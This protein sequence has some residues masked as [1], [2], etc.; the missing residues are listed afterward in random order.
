ML[1]EPRCP[2][3]GK[4]YTP[5]DGPTRCATCGTE[6]PP[7]PPKPLGIEGWFQGSESPPW[8]PSSE[9]PPPVPEAI[10]PAPAVVEQPPPLPPP[11]EEV[12]LLDEPP[13]PPPAPPP[14]VPVVRPSAVR[15]SSAGEPPTARVTTS[16][17]LED[18]PEARR[19]P[20]RGPDELVRPPLPPVRETAPP[21]VPKPRVFLALVVLLAVF[22]AGAC[23]LTVILY[24]LWAGF[25]A[26]S[27]PKSEA[28]VARCSV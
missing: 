3:C 10:T 16:R 22:V 13:K 11:A 12:I 17:R 5:A 26:A 27:K 18:L 25:N 20:R 9:T 28:I 15:G 23:G 24:A 4:P 2:Q 19:T 14:V 7:E 8:A 6:L 21:E 1:D